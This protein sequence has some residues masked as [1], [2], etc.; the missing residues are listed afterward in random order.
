[1]IQVFTGCIKAVTASYKEQRTV[2][3]II[4][5]Q[6]SMEFVL[7]NYWIGDSIQDARKLHER[8]MKAYEDMC[9]D[10]PF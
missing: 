7:V 1:M 8:K 5:E 3:K 9:M 2:Q 4:S 10:D 6:K